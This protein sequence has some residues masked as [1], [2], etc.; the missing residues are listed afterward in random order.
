[1]SFFKKNIT[2]TLNLFDIFILTLIFFGQAIYQ[3]TEEFLNSSDYGDTALISSYDLKI[4]NYWG[5]GFELLS[6][7]IAAIYLFIRHFN[8]RLF[9]FNINRYTIPLTLIFILTAD[10]IASLYDYLSFN[11]FSILPK[12]VNTDNID[13][14][15]SVDFIFYSLL[16]GF[17]EEFFFL[18]ILF[19]ISKKYYPIMYIYSLLI[20]FSFHTYQ[21]ISDALAI[22]T[23]GIVF[24]IFRQRFYS[25][26]PF[27]LAHAFF[28]VFGLGVLGTFLY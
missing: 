10:I 7:G 18:G 8:F 12:K 24:I 17:Y 1:M 25:L 19:F 26:I 15:W 11:F 14:S 22:T 27:M 9:N 21:G 2:N 16:N 4:A 28:D 5:I 13:F 20:R 23:L 3:S 6:L